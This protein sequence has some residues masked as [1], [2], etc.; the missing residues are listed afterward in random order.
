MKIFLS[1]GTHGDWQD[2]VRLRLSDQYFYDP[3][4]LRG[5]PMRE[6]AETE[7]SWLNSSDCLFFYFELSNPSGLGSAF[8]VGYCRARG[9]PII[10]VD[11]KKTSHTE[12]LGYHCTHYVASL[13]EGLDL[14][15][16]H[17]TEGR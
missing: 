17:V 9:I 16:A 11:E 2:R 14:L 10:F 15:E 3:R 6:I 5:K 1:G 12:W 13:E 4:S 7:M 8:E